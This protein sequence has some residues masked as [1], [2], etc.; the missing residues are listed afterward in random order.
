MSADIKKLLEGVKNGDVSVEE[1]LL[2]LKTKHFEDI[3]YA[4]KADVHEKLEQGAREAVC[5]AEK[6]A[7]N[8]KAENISDEICELNCNVDDMTG[9]AV[10]FTT[11]RLFE[12]GALDVYTTAIGMKKSRPGI[13]IHIICCE[14]DKKA[15]IE[16]V[17]KHT[18]TLGV[19]E[20]KLQRYVLEREIKTVQTSYGNVRCKVSKGYGV[21]RKKYE[22]E[23]LAKI[24]KETGKSIGELI[25]EF[26]LG[27]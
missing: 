2:K 7:Q 27:E 21:E 5:D 17:F 10:G 1:A 12:A 16:T 15:I 25:T 24:A 3:D 18:T 9:E 8:N 6:S 14:K 13:L 23:D 20:N 4:A 11:E 26:D 22:Y 19:R